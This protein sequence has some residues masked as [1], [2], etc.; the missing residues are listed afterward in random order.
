MA[1]GRPPYGAA[2]ER[3]VKMESGYRCAIS[4]C[5]QHPVQLHHIVPWAQCREHRFENLIALCG[6]CHALAENGTID[7]VAQRKYKA[8][9]SIVNARYSEMERRAIEIYAEQIRQDREHGRVAYG[10]VGGG[11]INLPQL[12]FETDMAFFFHNLLKDGLIWSGGTNPA[13]TRYS[14]TKEGLAFVSDWM[15]GRELDG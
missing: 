6:N 10:A 5:R 8:N 1:D 9:L 4:T 3:A 13:V 14:L 11:W 12:E 15:E 7:R 2:L